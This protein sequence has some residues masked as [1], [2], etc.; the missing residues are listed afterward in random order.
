MT[1]LLLDKGYLNDDSELP[2]KPLALKDLEMR[3]TQ[4]SLASSLK[5]SKILPHLTKLQLTECEL[6][7][8]TDTLVLPTLTTLRSAALGRALNA[9]SWYFALFFG[10]LAEKKGWRMDV[11]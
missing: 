11:L 4:I 5:L 10:V 8:S 7:G 2:D 1:K 3:D 6:L 9:Y